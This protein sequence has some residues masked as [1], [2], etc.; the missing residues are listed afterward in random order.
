MKT[1]TPAAANSISNQLHLPSINSLEPIGLHTC[2]KSRLRSHL[3]GRGRGCTGKGCVSSVVTGKGRVCNV[4]TR[5]GCVCTV[6][7]RKGCA[8]QR[9]CLNLEWEC[10]NTKMGVSQQRTQ[11]VSEV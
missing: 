1:K 2:G 11:V 4:A 10:L 3:S 5:K 9:V 6:A 8:K 7:T